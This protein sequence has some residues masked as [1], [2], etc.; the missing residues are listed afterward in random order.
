[1][2]LT[3]KFGTTWKLFLIGSLSTEFNFTCSSTVLT[4]GIG[5]PHAVMRLRFSI[6]LSFFAVCGICFSK[7]EEITLVVEPVSIKAAT[8]LLPTVTNIVNGLYCILH[9]DG[10]HCFVDTCPNAIISVRSCSCWTVSW[11]G[12]WE[13]EFLSHFLRAIFGICDKLFLC[14]LYSCK[15]NRFCLLVLPGTLRFFGYPNF[16]E[17]D[18]AN[19]SFVV[20][21]LVLLDGDSVSSRYHFAIFV[22]AGN[23]ACV[24][25][26]P[27]G[28]AFLYILGYNFC[29]FRKNGL[30]SLPLASVRICVLPFL[31]LH[32]RG[33]QIIV[34]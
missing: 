19:Y 17:Y 22:P 29:S 21:F 11:L 34:C 24:R 18:L 3:A 23:T 12:L 5:S 25:P 10:S 32:L 2:Q 33:Q 13:L 26:R 31:L 8:R 4:F 20:V 9:W 6:D 16:L 1:M 28:F 30:V 27:P 7:S 15:R 14:V